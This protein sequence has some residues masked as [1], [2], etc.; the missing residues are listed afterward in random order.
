MAPSFADWLD[1]SGFLALWPGKPW[2][3]SINQPD[4]M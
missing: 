4:S 1:M 2:L 3:I